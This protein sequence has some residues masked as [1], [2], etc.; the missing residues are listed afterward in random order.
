M[1]QQSD[2]PGTAVLD[3]LVQR[4]RSLLERAGEA[5]TQEQALG[6][7]VAVYLRFSRDRILEVFA[8][9]V[10]RTEGEDVLDTLTSNDHANA[11]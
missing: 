1:G 3:L 5:V 6:R 7:L 11:T 10:A 2:T 8:E 9:A 4:H